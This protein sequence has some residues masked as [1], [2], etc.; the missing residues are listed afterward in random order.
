MELLIVF[1]LVWSSS[2]SVVCYLNGMKMTGLI[3]ISL[4]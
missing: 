3:T 1:F 4:K 2:E